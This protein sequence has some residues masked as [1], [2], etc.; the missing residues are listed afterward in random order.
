MPVK[1]CGKLDEAVRE[2]AKDSKPGDIV[3]LS[4]AC[5]SFDQ[6]RTSRIAATGSGSW[7]GRYDGLISDRLR[8][9]ISVDANRTAAPTARRS[10]A[11][12]GR[13][14]GCCCS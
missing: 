12:S 2:A 7:W 14:T 8:A 6:F 4:P 3:L 13:S 9:S 1:N 11:G 10:A 5:A